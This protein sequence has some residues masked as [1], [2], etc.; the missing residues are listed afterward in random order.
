MC[1]HGLK[2]SRFCF[3]T[4]V[5]QKM[6]AFR[7]W[8]H[9]DC[10]GKLRLSRTGTELNVLGRLNQCRYDSHPGVFYLRNEA[11][12]VLTSQESNASPKKFPASAQG[13][14]RYTYRIVFIFFFH[15]RCKTHSVTL[16]LHWNVW[17]HV[18]APSNMIFERIF[19]SINSGPVFLL[20]FQ[21]SYLIFIVLA[22]FLNA[23]NSQVFFCVSTRVSPLWL[24]RGKWFSYKLHTASR[25]EDG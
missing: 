21:F 12:I 9:M 23:N 24:V 18:F 11:W 20:L 14:W 1:L 7:V 15:P 19:L 3:L 10:A 17:V 25:S 22:C 16:S 13:N 5:A 8:V 4:I 6:K 2:Y